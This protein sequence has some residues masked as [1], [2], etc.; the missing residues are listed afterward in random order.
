METSPSRRDERPVA[1][2]AWATPQLERL[3]GRN[4]VAVGVAG[5]TDGE[6]GSTTFTGSS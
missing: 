2:P 1:R 6:V 3:R 4:D 5:G